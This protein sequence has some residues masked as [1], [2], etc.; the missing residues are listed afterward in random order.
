MPLEEIKK[1]ASAAAFSRV[2]LE[3]T[4]VTGNSA[5]RVEWPIILSVAV[6][7]FLVPIYRIHAISITKKLDDS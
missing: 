7:H 5:L 4:T 1:K 3:C 6:S 2:F